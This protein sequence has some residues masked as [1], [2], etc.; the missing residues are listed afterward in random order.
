MG[1]LLLEVMIGYTRS[2]E[3]EK[4]RGSYI[5][6]L[7]GDCRAEQPEMWTWP[8]AE[9]KASSWAHVIL[10]VPAGKIYRPTLSRKRGALLHSHIHSFPSP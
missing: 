10:P 6:D 5:I 3:Q 7:D 2:G 9:H 1:G 4:A 8:T